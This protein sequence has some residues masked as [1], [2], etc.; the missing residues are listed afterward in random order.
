[1]SSQENVIK[2]GFASYY[3][4][5]ALALSQLGIIN[6]INKCKVYIDSDCEYEVLTAM[7]HLRIVGTE[8]R[9]YAVIRALNK[10]EGRMLIYDDLMTYYDKYVSM[11][12]GIYVYEISYWVPSL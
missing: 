8:I 3:S 10:C 9:V 1:M 5:L 2:L 12:P 7:S 6:R 4:L 11:E